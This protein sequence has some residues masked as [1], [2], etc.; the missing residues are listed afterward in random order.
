MCVVWVH[1]H[2]CSC[3]VRITPEVHLNV[4][5]WIGVMWVYGCL[6]AKCSVGAFVNTCLRGDLQMC[7]CRWI[8]V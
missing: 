3:R 4:G 8:R 1:E 6:W 5:G 2:V 7:V